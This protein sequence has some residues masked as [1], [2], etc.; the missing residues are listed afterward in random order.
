MKRLCIL[1]ILFLLLMGTNAHA[2]QNAA[3]Q[4]QNVFMEA[5][6]QTWRGAGKAITWTVKVPYLAGKYILT[7]LCRPFVPIRNK[8]VDM[9]GVEVQE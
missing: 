9:F 7:E 8:L 4:N 5:T 3:G 6:R 2:Y 1:I